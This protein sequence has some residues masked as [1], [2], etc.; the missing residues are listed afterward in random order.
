MFHEQIF[1]QGKK[2]YCW[3][4]RQNTIIGP[5]KH[6]SLLCISPVNQKYNKHYGLFEPRTIWPGP[7]MDVLDRTKR[8]AM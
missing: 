3:Q 8:P 4:Y 1:Y 2:C 5:T 7:N 6:D